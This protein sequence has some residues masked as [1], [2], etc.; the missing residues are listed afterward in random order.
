[1]DTFSCTESSP[2]TGT[3]WNDMAH[4]HALERRVT[5]ESV[6][7]S[8]KNSL[9]SPRLLCVMWLGSSALCRVFWSNPVFNTDSFFL[10]FS[11]KKKIWLY[12]LFLSLSQIET[13]SN[14]QPW[15]SIDDDEGRRTEVEQ[16]LTLSSFSTHLALYV[17]ADWAAT[18][19]CPPPHPLR[20]HPLRREGSRRNRRWW[21]TRCRSP[22]RNWGANSWTTR[23]SCSKSGARWGGGGRSGGVV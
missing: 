3:R 14:L 16:R 12:W 4:A 10:F 7:V 6:N 22:T 17:R 13:L 21:P 8:P 5:K 2:G 19:R 1:M 20:L 11:L 18:V 23:L 9:F 15:C